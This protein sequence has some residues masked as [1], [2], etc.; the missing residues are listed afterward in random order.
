LIVIMSRICTD[1]S[2]LFSLYGNDVHTPKAIAWIRSQSKPIS[3]SSFNRFE[4]A[5]ALRF[6]EFRG[7]VESGAAA[8][9]W[10]DFEADLSAG[11]L[12]PQI[13]NLAE[14]L[15]EATRLSATHTLTGGHRSFDIL[16]V[17]AALHL[18]STEF[19][20][21]DANQRDLARKEQL[22]V[23]CANS[24]SNHILAFFPLLAL[25]SGAQFIEIAFRTRS[26][27]GNS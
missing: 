23:P 2:F 22:S 3:I 18:E 8:R 7:A 27:P 15:C 4:L 11:R 21:F 12:V 16:H 24:C 6:A 14:V 1:T 10:A 17:A 13:C 9:Y 5:N 20:T 25:T 26:V 19:L